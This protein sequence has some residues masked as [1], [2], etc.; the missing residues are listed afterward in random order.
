MCGHEELIV[1]Y[2]DLTVGHELITVIGCN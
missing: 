2:Q 1:K